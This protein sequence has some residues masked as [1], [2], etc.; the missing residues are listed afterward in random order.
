MIEMIRQA[1]IP[2]G[3]LAT[4]ATLPGALELLLVTGGA[5]RRRASPTVQKTESLALAIIVPAHNEEVF[6]GRCVE[7]LLN[8]AATVAACAVV[9]VADNCIDATADRARQAGARVLVRENAVQRGKGFALRFAFDTLMSEGFDGFLI[10]DADS[11]VSADLVPAIASGLF[12]GA[13]ALQTRYRVTKPLDTNRKRLMDVALLA[14]NVLRPFGRYGWGLSAGILG[15]GFALS[16]KTLLAVPYS[17][18]SIVEDLEYHLLLV[19]NGKRVDFIDSA[20]VYGDMPTDSQAQESQRARWE[21]GRARVAMAWIPK[22]TSRFLRGHWGV[23]EPLMELLTLPLAYLTLLALLLCVIPFPEFRI[24][25]LFL[26]G[27]LVAHVASS[28]ALGGNVRESLSALASAPGYVF[29]K[30]TRM[31]SIIK[32]SRRETQWLRTPRASD[33]KPEV[34]HV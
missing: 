26:V 18:D 27:L 8:S 10:I 34:P 23:A 25:G 33:A 24:Y 12:N 16:R 5:L 2:V 11:I 30:L 13:D 22:L 15:N 14:F 9:V 6:I 19:D 1:L 20:T 21:G 7:S 28:V 3:A 4:L 29:W 32:S 31:G 17:A